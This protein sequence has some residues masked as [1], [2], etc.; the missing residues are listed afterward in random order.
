MRKKFFC[1]VCYVFA[2]LL[3]SVYSV[4]AQN[5]RINDR[6]RLYSIESGD[7]TLLIKAN[8]DFSVPVTVRLDLEL[9]NLRLLDNDRLVVI[10]A[11]SSGNVVARLKKITP[12]DPY[13]CIYNWKIV[14]GDATR[15]PDD[16][17]AYGYPYQSPVPL[18]VSQGPGGDFS[19]HGSFAYDFA[20]P[21]GSLVTAARDGIVAFVDTKWT[22]GGKDQSLLD[23][24]NVI[25]ILHADGTIGN[26]VH[27]S[28]DGS[29]VQEGDL[30]TKG[31]VIA[32][33][34]NTGF[35]SGPHLHFEVVQPDVEGLKKKW[36]A[37][38]WEQP[39]Y[40]V[41]QV[42]PADQPVTMGAPAGNIQPGGISHHSSH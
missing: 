10:P 13:T 32:L 15:V 1:S 36:V 27:L 24:A 38:R 14:L 4:F 2:L 9:G 17:F 26:Y 42:S 22:A 21:V 31:Q 23:K 28:K 40:P 6:T 30:V 19:H 35:S 37:F 3:L 20:M 41:V 7:D 12:D 34:G 18:P 11:K 25:S 29:F 16:N 5:Y 33:S 8:N 39:S